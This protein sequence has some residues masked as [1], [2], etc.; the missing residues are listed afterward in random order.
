MTRTPNRYRP[1]AGILLLNSENQIFTGE[2]LDTP[3]AWQ[4]PQGGIDPGE[5]PE[6]AALRELEEEIG[7]TPK[8]VIIEAQTKD[9]IY[10]DLPDHLQRKAFKG[11]FLGQR[12][13]WFRMRLLDQDSAINI[14]TQH[15]EFG[16]W[17]W[18]TRE[19]VQRDIV[20]FKRNVYAAV[21]EELLPK[22]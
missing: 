9:W 4:M 22:P 7:V 5:K 16:R 11:S 17:K 12:Q 2:R 8:S 21:L 3:G 10:Y 20:A 1:C 19:S 15:P 6:Q 18:S 14:H 13:Q